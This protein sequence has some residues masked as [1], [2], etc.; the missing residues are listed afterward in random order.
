MKYIR[1]RKRLTFVNA[2]W[3]RSKL[4]DGNAQFRDLEVFSIGYAWCKPQHCL[5]KQWYLL[6]FDLQCQEICFER[7]SRIIVRSNIRGR[8]LWLIFLSMTMLMCW[9]QLEKVLI[10]SQTGLSC[11]KQPLTWVWW[12]LWVSVFYTY[13]ALCVLWYLRSS[14]SPFLVTTIFCFKWFYN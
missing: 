9:K 8:L 1:R 6:F 14:F 12:Y 5:W 4:W 11:Y 3:T 10:I 7:L 2:S 13:W